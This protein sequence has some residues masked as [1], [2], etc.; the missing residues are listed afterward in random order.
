MGGRWGGAPR[1]F[2]AMNFINAAEGCLKICGK[3]I[4]YPPRQNNDALFIS[5]FFFL[6]RVPAFLVYKAVK[7]KSGLHY[8]DI[9]GV[10]Q[11]INK[12]LPL[13]QPEP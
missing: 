7:K 10:H 2:M 5:F 3:F 12:T 11:A 9:L 1:Y 13:F 4:V 6:I 8:S